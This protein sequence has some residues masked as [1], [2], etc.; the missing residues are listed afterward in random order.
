MLIMT[1]LFQVLSS[2]N[3]QAA[4]PLCV[5]YGESKQKEDIQFITIYYAILE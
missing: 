2:I 1:T 5:R 4:Y 3:S